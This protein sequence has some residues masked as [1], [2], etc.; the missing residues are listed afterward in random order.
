[1]IETEQI[2]VLLTLAEVAATFAGFSALVTLFG[3]RRVAGAAV[4]DLLRLR[5]VI[6]ASMAALMAALI[7]VA[8]EGYG[9][10]AAVTWRVSALAFLALIYFTIAS[11]FASYRSV[12]D[13]FL[14][15]RLAA[16]VALVLEVFIQ[17][18]LLAIVFGM[19]GERQYGFFVSALIGTIGQAAF[20]FLRLVES[21]FGA[22]VRPDIRDLPP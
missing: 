16:M 2:N 19:A 4:H 7:P 13:E 8:L 21:T 20:V 3:R 12:R 22:I 5:L 1:M 17:I 9:L 18:G 15:D 6:G 11:F 10:S 14:P